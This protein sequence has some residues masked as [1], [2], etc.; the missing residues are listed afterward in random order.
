MHHRTYQQFSTDSPLI[1]MINGTPSNFTKGRVISPS[2]PVTLP[3]QSAISLTVSF[4]TPLQVMELVLVTRHPITAFRTTIGND[5]TQLASPA[6]VVGVAWYIYVITVP[7]QLTTPAD[8]VTIT[9]ELLQQTNVIGFT[10]KAC[11][12]KSL[13]LTR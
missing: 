13:S 3:L 1:S 2:N 4:T 7:P 10:I 6:M 9:I 8:R 5:T 11:T 12:G